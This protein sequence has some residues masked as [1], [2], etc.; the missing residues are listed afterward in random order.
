MAMGLPN[1]FIEFVKTAIQSITVGATGIVGVI[2]KDAAALAGGYTI[3]GTEVIPDGLSDA[4][5]ISSEN[6]SVCDQS[7]G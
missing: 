6:L 1:I 3:S 4:N 5:G 2:L 7:G